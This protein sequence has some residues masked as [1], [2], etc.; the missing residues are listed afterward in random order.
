MT[1][2]SSGYNKSFELLR[3]RLP[4]VFDLRDVAIALKTE[5][6]LAKIYCSRWVTRKMA[7]PLGPR[8]GVFFNLVRD[9]SADKTKLKDGVDKLIRHRVVVIGATALHQHGWTTQRPQSIEMAVP[10]GGPDR[11]YPEMKGITTV[12]RKREWFHAVK[13]SC[14]IGIDG[15]YTVSPEI[16]LVDAIMTGGKS[17]IWRPDPSDIDLPSDVEPSDAVAKIMSAAETLGTNIEE[18]VEFI[19]DVDGLDDQLPTP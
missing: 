13:S 8:A 6:K 9:P 17:G 2:Q 11:T 1:P 3:D 7:A 5:R 12:L 16:A 19:A 15:F 4:D 10:V 14:E 18:I